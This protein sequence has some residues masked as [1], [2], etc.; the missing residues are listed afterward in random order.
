MS[1]GARCHGCSALLAVRDGRLAPHVPGGG[2]PGSGH[3]ALQG[4]LCPAS[5]TVPWRVGVPDDATVRALLQDHEL[6]PAFFALF[7]V[8]SSGMYPGIVG[9]RFFCD[10]TDVE[11][12]PGCVPRVAWVYG[13]PADA[14]G[15]EREGRI[16]PGPRWAFR[17]LDIDLLKPRPWPLET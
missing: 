7:Q 3:L 16:W 8:Q 2:E 11:C 6:Y 1:T 15:R 14:H 13:F 10:C 12:E 17:P 9:A 5:G 4:A